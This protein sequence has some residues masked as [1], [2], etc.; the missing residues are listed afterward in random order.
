MDDTSDALKRIVFVGG[1][2]RSGTTLIQQ[3]LNY[4][5]AV[6]GGPE[7]DFVPE[8]ADL[9]RR[10]RQSIRSGRIDNFL[11]EASDGLRRVWCLELGG[12]DRFRKSRSV[13]SVLEVERLAA[14]RQ[15]PPGLRPL[16]VEVQ[17]LFTVLQP[18]WHRIP[19]Y[20]RRDHR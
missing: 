14:S 15:G 10:M 1:S 5:P 18:D 6:Y 3:L 11:N 9:F 16:N 7:F 12:F 2:P 13:G 19:E 4:H 17:L 20:V 8:I